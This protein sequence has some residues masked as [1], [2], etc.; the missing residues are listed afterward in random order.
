M[1]TRIGSQGPTPQVAT[2]TT[3]ARLTPTPARPFQNVLHASA[4]L[5]VSSAESAVR[6]MPGGAVLA[7]AVRPSPA[8]VTATTSPEGSTTASDDPAGV[9]SANSDAGLTSA[10]DSMADQNLYY[11]Q[12]QQQISAENREY[13]TLSNVLK[14]R[15]D[16]MKNAIGNLR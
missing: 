12:L 16:T 15:H 10:L 2:T 8:R 7:A 5:V 6:A 1:T 9:V 4:R 13:T 14:T 11:L 3:T